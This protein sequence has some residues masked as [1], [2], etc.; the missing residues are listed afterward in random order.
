MGSFL[1]AC[2]NSQEGPYFGKTVPQHPA[3]ELWINGGGSPQY[4]DPSLIHD[5]V[6]SQ[7]GRNQF[8]RLVEVST[9]TGKPIPDLATHWE[10]SND[11]SEYTFHLRSDAK[12]SDGKALTAQDIEWTWK[13]VLNPATGSMSGALATA[14]ANASAFSHRAIYVHT[15]NPHEAFDR[16]GF[17]KTLQSKF[18]IEKFEEPINLSGLFVYVSDSVEDKQKYRADLLAYI[19]AKMPHLSAKV[20]DSSVVQVRALDTHTLWVKLIG[21][22]P[23]FLSMLDYHVFAPVPQHAIEAAK[24]KTGREELWVR[25][26]H[27]VVS[28]PYKLTEEK[29]KQYRYFEKNPYYYDAEFVKTPKIKVL[30]LED[31]NTSLNIYR[32]G[33][34]DWAGSNVSVPAHFVDEI[35]KYRDYSLSPQLVMY[36]FYLNVSKPELSNKHLRK[37]LSLAIDRKTMVEKVT[38]AGQIPSAN[39]IPCG[40]AGYTCAPATLF[41]PEQARKELAQAGYKK[42]D[43]LPPIEIKYN[44]AESHRKIAEA[45][46][47]MWKKHLGIDVSLHNLEWRVFLHDRTEGNFQLARGGWIGDYPDPQ[48]F[49]QLLL[50]DSSTNITRWK[51]KQFDELMKLSD[52]ELDPSHRLELMRQAEIIALDESP[53]IP[54]YVYT[55][56]TLKKPYLMGHYEDIQ[57]YHEWKYMWIDDR[58]YNEVPES[59]LPQKPYKS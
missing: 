43:K 53:I 21:P 31:Y 42:G 30:V 4:M 40:L 51:N 36:Y 46:Q 16:E 27:I 2:T 28:G 32:T 41:D 26:E 55:K 48:N 7:F 58:W 1:F 22:L 47:Q 13:R 23:Y 45:L 35:K 10:V 20:A 5:S 19:A 18:K 14:F 6:S 57:D 50:S 24:K 9:Q 54:I 11:L 37:A 39:L 17:E 8:V 44:T 15:R 49:F 59:S 52:R 34:M 38:R 56:G 29:F 25:P 3:D 33:G 12:W